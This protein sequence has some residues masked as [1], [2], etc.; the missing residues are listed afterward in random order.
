MTFDQ[1]YEAV[2]SLVFP[3]DEADNLIDRHRA[4][5]QDAMVDLQRHVV[6]LQENNCTVVR[7]NQSKVRC[8]AT[9]LDP[10]EGEIQRVQTYMADGACAVREFTEITDRDM[11]RVSRNYTQCIAQDD[12]PATTGTLEDLPP[13]DPSESPAER[14]RRSQLQGADRL[15]VQEREGHPDLPTPLHG[16]VGVRVCAASRASTTGS[17]TWWPRPS[18]TERPSGPSST[19]SRPKSTASSSATARPTRSRWPSTR[20]PASTSSSIAGAAPSCRPVRSTPCTSCRV[21]GADAPRI[22]RSGPVGRHHRLPSVRHGGRHAGERHDQAAHVRCANYLAGDQTITIW[23]CDDGTNLLP[24]GTDILQADDDGILMRIYVREGP[25][26]GIAM[27]NPPASVYTVGQPICTPTIADLQ[28]ST[29]NVLLVIV[30]SDNNGQFA[31]FA[32]SDDA[33]TGDGQNTIVNAI[34]VTYVRKS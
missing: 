8:G 32:R 25:T 13:C 26:D 10:V 16:R 1:L 14:N 20:R 29:Y 31:M 3:E 27:P 33:G 5:V 6:C 30:I 11:D 34:G 28:S 23:I 15:V 9:I 22:V 18:R 7:Q 21:A 19:I 17:R 2:K 12:D 24:N 4:W